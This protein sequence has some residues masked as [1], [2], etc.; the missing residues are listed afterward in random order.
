MAVQSAIKFIIKASQDTSFR[1]EFYGIEKEEIKK[2]QEDNGFEFE[3][4]EFEEAKYVLLFKAQSEAEAMNI[5]E[6]AM[7]YYMVNNETTESRYIG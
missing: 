1:S 4:C 7:W 3:M 6:I 2:L 5:K